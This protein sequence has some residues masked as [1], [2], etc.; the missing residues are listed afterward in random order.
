VHPATAHQD[1]VR[2]NLVEEPIVDSAAQVA[3]E[4]VPEPVMEAEKKFGGARFSAW[5]KRALLASRAR[6]LTE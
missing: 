1:A 3:V 2:D 4:A 6:T 5:S